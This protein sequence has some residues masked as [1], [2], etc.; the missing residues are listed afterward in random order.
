[1]KAIK[2]VFLLLFVSYHAIGQNVM[3]SSPYSMFG[4]GEI[5]TGLHGQ[6]SAMG[7]AAY[8]SRNLLFIN[9]D[10]PAGLVGMDSCKLIV[11]VSGFAKYESY[12]SNNNSND[13]FT[14]NVSAFMMGGRVM[15]RWYTAVSVTPY[16]SVGYYFQSTQ[17]L[18]GT[19][20]STVSSV[21]E[22]SGGL[23][24]ASFSNAFLLPR[25]ISVGV[26]LSYVFG[27]MKQIETQDG[28]TITQNMQANALYADFGIQ[29]ERAL[30]KN[31]VLTLGAVYGYQHKLNID[32]KQTIT[33]SLTSTEE[34]QKG[35]D[36]YLPQFFGLGGNLIHKKM[37]YGLDYTFHQY[38]SLSSGDSR[39][40]FND[41]HEFSGGVCFSP[42]SY[43][44]NSYWKRMKYKAGLKMSNSYLSI[45]KKDG[46]LWR[47]SA[48]LDF[49]VRNG[50]ISAAVFYESQKLQNNKFQSN[51]I[52]LTVSCTISE[53]F[54]KVKL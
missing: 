39:V 48:G 7:G 47:A 38:S 11:D 14:G 30:G 25:K 49:P 36:Q 16:S 9:T 24:K 37:T 15:P 21:F 26:N 31:T 52:G 50:L 44:A 18:E 17:D 41:T 35:A 54:Y 3:T 13:A 2:P 4:I 22:G 23:S 12:K 46:L 42:E 28:M 1:M 43:Y 6:N 27:N 45:S 19:S 51:I 10:N 53:L 8:G 20:G 40:T 33:T 34:S 32:N 29:Y 5:T